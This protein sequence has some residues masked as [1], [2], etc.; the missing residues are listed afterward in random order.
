MKIGFIG[1]GNMGGALAVAAGKS[2]NEILL[3]DKDTKKAKDIALK[4]DG[5]VLSLVEIINQSNYIFLGVKPQVLPDLLKDIDDILKQSDNNPVF[6]SM[7]AGTPLSQINDL[8]PINTPVLRIMPN[9]PVMVGEGVILICKN[10][11]ATEENINDFELF[12]SHGGEII[13]IEEKFIDAASAISGCGP[14]FVYM[15]IEALADGGVSAGLTSDLSIKL[16]AATL[17]GAAE[18][19]LKSGKHPGKLKADVCSPGGTTIAGVRSLEEHNFRA[20]AMDAVI[21][22]YKRTL[23]LAG[24]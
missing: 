21:S 18:M 6:I 15:F 16:A 5:K 17:K 23:E 24:K 8:L 1:A 19:A 7:A 12:M 9:L 13:P 14:A 4:C 2:N 11:S 10:N 22:S 3:F 20:T